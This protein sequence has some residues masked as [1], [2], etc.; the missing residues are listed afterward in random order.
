MI[1]I[2]L[3]GI[4]PAL[5]FS[6]NFFFF[7]EK[8][9]KGVM[10][11]L[12][13]GQPAALPSLLCQTLLWEAGG[14]G[15][16]LRALRESTPCCLLRSALPGLTHCCP[17]TTGQLETLLTA[18]RQ[19]WGGFLALVF[20]RWMSRFSGCQRAPMPCTRLLS[21]SRYRAFCCE[22]RS[23]RVRTTCEFFP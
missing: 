11:F 20:S 6:W 23:T 13:G 8:S 7:L 5:L 2:S 3:K 16:S 15:C 18:L 21:Q 12:E 10:I 9:T 1:S 17:L 19:V 4:L 22:S 14:A